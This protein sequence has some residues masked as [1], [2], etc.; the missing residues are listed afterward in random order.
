MIKFFKNTVRSLLAKYGYHVVYHPKDR[1]LTGFNMSY[2]LQF[3]IKSECPVCFDV[4]ANKGQTIGLF[5]KTFKTPQIYAFEP[6][7]ELFGKLKLKDYDSQVFLYNLAL[8][9]QN[10]QQEFINYKI[11]ELS[12]FLLLDNDRDNPFRNVKI[13]NKEIVDIKTIDLFVKENNINRIDLL[14]IDTQGY[15]LEVLQ[16]A[17][18]CFQKGLI[19]N[20]LVELNFIKM[21]DNQ[22]DLHS[23]STFLADRNLYLVDYYGK[24][25]KKHTLGWCNG[26]F[27]KR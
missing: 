25:Y 5:K 18:D 23:I 17:Q 24:V 1:G 12:S 2:D 14:K 10:C 21:Y 9:Q 22:S 16:G 4:G 11:P 3:I 19:D 26:L 8:G 6:S 13:K 20:V 15:D 7:S 27:T